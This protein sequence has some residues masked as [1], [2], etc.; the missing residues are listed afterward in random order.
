MDGIHISIGCLHIKL[1]RSLLGYLFR[2]SQGDAL[3]LCGLRSQRSLEVLDLRSLGD[4]D[5]DLT[6]VVS[7]SG[8]FDAAV[9]DFFVGLQLAGL[10]RT[11]L[12][13][14][15]LEHS[16]GLLEEAFNL[17]VPDDGIAV[18]VAGEHRHGFLLDS[19]HAERRNLFLT[20]DGI[21]GLAGD[22]LAVNVFVVISCAKDGL[23]KRN[24]DVHSFHCSFS[25]SFLCSS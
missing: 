4:D 22:E 9:D 12:A 20:A 1:R 24:L 7:V 23:C 19:L 10:F 2:I 14:H 17:I 11:G 16:A 8:R 13:L 21:R 5:R 15:A 18:L 3:T 6:P 25:F